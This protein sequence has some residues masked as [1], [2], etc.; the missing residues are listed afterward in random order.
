M[1]TISAQLLR[2][3]VGGL[4]ANPNLTGEL[5]DYAWFNQHNP[6]PMLRRAPSSLQA[7]MTRHLPV[8]NEAKR[9]IVGQPLRHFGDDYYNTIHVSA[10]LLELGNVVTTQTIPVYV[11]NAYLEPKNLS[12]ITGQVE[13]L[14]LTGQPEPPLEYPGNGSREY[15]LSVE[16]YGAPVIDNTLNWVFDDVAVEPVSVPLLV[17]GRRIIAWSWAP[18]WSDGMTERLSWL[19]DILQSES[20]V[21]Q[22]RA[23]RT[24]PR[25]EFEIS[26]YAEGRE[27]QLLDIALFGWSQRTWAIP[28]WP[29]IQWLSTPV[30]L[31]SLRIDCQTADLDFTV[32]SLAML[33]GESAFDYEVVEVAAID[34]TGL[35]LARATQ[36]GW[37]SGT[38]LYPA[39]TAQLVEQP[40]LK[41]LTDRLVQMDVRFLITEPCDWPKGLPTTLYR[42]RPVLE[43]RPDESEELSSSCQRNLLTLDSSMAL[44]AVLDT[45]GLA[46]PVQGHRWL[47][48]GR[49]ARSSYRKLLYALIGRVGELW[50]PTHADDLTLAAQITEGGTTLEVENIGYAR[51]GLQRT[52][53]KDIR[54]E[55]YD[56][57]VFHRRITDST[58]VSG[59]LERL[60]INAALGRLVTPTQIA[61]ISWMTL[62]RLDSDSVEIDHMTDSEGVAASSLTFRGV[63]DDDFF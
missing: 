8:T 27:R 29:D 26:G 58:E 43:A 31:G 56:G 24:T 20:M 16:T 53:R 12:A 19:T 42:N 51:F 57:T 7:A 63:R 4:N 23:L 18:D 38:R 2:P 14:A 11:W 35:T 17:T 25:R 62:C 45:A 37:P 13:G 50:V 5:W 55:L 46:M 30:T 32:G 36:S 49:S 47:E 44:P 9:A 54:I 21:E 60:E 40:S 28:I 33:R 61:R 6:S 15:L 34:A 41:R 10:N 3:G 39:R 22:R 52:G 48:L 1:P 59:T